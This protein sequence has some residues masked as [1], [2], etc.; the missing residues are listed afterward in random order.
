MDKTIRDWYEKFQQSGWK[1]TGQLGQLA[2]TVECVQLVSFRA[3]MFADNAPD[4]CNSW[5]VQCVDF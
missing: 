4:T 1:Q 5:L 2:E 3:K